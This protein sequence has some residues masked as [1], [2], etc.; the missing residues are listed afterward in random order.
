MEPTEVRFLI[1]R[2][3][4]KRPSIEGLLGGREPRGGTFEVEESTM[5]TS[6]GG[7]EFL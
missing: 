6:Y 1:F 4:F 5:D 3:L 2:H 7:K